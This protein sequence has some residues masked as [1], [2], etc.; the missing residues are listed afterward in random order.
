[1]GTNFN[2][3]ATALWNA[4]TGCA[5]TNCGQTVHL[6]VYAGYDETSVWQEFGEM[7]F[8]NKE[9][10]PHAVW[11]NPNPKKPNWVAQP[12][13]AVDLLVRGRAAVGPVLDPPGR[14]LGHDHARDRPHIFSVGDNNNNPYVTPYHR[15]GSGPWDMMD[16]G[17]FNGPGGPHNRWLVPGAVRAPRWA[18]STTLRIEGRHGLRARTRRCCGVNRNGL[19]QSGPGGR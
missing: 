18:P 12:L 3:D 16:R 9:D 11:G 1:M 4:D 13:R 8:E 6:F 5:A 14:E 2:S 10:I 15:V 7:K 17:S 19:A